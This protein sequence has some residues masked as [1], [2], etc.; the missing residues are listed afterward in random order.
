MNVT[1]PTY[2]ITLA[3]IE[4]DERHHDKVVEWQ[5][6]PLDPIYTIIYLDCLVVKIRQDKRV[7]NES[8][9]LALVINTED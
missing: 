7:I 2:H 8:I 5:S 6:R 9:F 3:Y 1:G 4:S